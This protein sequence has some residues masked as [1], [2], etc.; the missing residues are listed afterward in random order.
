MSGIHSPVSE[1]GPS[2][3][4]AAPLRPVGANDRPHLAHIDGMRAVAAL[5]VVWCHLAPRP[6]GDHR[7]QSLTLRIIAKLSTH[8]HFAVTVF[9]V[10]SGFCLMLP[11]VRAGTTLRGGAGVFFKRRFWRIAPPMYAAVLLSIFILQL[12]HVRVAYGYSQVTMTQVVAHALLLQVPVP[13]GLLPNNGPLWSISVE[14]IMYLFFPVIIALSRRFGSRMVALICVVAG[15]A[16]LFGLRGTIPGAVSWQYLGAFALGAAAADSAYSATVNVGRFAHRIPWHAISAM[17][18]AAVA[19]F[20]MVRGWARVVQY[21]ELLDLPIALS[22]A[23]LL[24]GVSRPGRDYVRDILSLPALASIG[25]FSYSLYLIHYPLVDLLYTYVVV[26]MKLGEV[27][28]EL[29]SC[30]VIVPAVVAIAY[31]F[32]LAFERPFH[33]IARRVKA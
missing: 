1:V 11:V 22:A 13:G 15:Y 9:I 20:A 32:Y 4:P 8:G 26:P 29:V 21:S 12:P 19:A 31:V 5:Y 2:A 7:P 14:S 3:D 23:A 25:L 27:G 24:V 30:V 28:S 6:W 33:L 17:G 10:I 16:L 18:V